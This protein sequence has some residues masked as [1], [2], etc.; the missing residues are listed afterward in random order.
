VTVILDESRQ[1]HRVQDLGDDLRA[2]DAFGIGL[3]GEKDAMTEDVHRD[4]FHILRRH[5]IATCE[6]GFCFGGEREE[7]TG[8]RRGAEA[9]EFLYLEA[10]GG[11][12]GGWRRRD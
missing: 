10:V 2:G 3:V 8:A 6:G 7:D 9:N 1:R 5:V 4:I 12:G 11:G